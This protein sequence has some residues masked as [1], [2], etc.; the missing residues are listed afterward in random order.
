MTIPDALRWFVNVG[1]I[2]EVLREIESGKESQIYLCRRAQ[3][4]GASHLVAKVYIPRAKRAFKGESVY[5]TGWFIRER[6]IRKA[7]SKMSRYGR[8]Y[9]ESRWVEQEF[10]TLR[11][12]WSLGADVPVPVLKH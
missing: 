12:L 4:G 3:R 6:T 2:R 1:V 5:R 8:A 10:Q 9:V 11:R 7:V